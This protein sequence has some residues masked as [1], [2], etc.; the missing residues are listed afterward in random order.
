[1]IKSLF[2]VIKLIVLEADYEKNMTMVNKH[3]ENSAKEI[4]RD[5]V[6]DIFEKERELVDKFCF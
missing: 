1:M 6:R 5:K 3:L 2:K 4:D